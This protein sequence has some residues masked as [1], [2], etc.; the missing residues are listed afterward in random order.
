MCICLY[1]VGL[2]ALKEEID[3]REQKKFLQRTSCKWQNLF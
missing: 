2:R 3:N 1:S